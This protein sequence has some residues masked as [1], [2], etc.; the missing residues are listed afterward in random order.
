MADEVSIVT[1]V[2]GRYATALFELARDKDQLDQVKRDLD[3]LQAMLDDSDDLMSLV[4]SPLYSAEVQD[5]AMSAVLA[6][7]DFASITQNFLHV[8]TAN[9]R[10]FAVEG[11]IKGFKALLSH[12]RGEVNAE[13]ISAAP[14]SDAQRAKLRDVLK[15]I[16][17]QDIEL[18]TKVDPSILGGLI[19]KL[20]SR[21]IDGSLRTKLNSM[22]TLMKE[23]G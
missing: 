12:H 13:A 1:G 22:K 21:Q 5:K 10:L 6:K 4:K 15:E 11:I 2:A 17:G 18:N 3:G 7:S 19:V 23:V 16:A 20:G 8:I 9:R 14:L